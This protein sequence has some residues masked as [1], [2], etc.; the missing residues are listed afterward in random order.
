V[1]VKKE[2]VERICQSTV[3]KRRKKSEERRKEEKAES[4]VVA[5]EVSPYPSSHIEV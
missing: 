2:K 1:R 4:V 5:S 3:K